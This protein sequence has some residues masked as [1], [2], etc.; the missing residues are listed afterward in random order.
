ME[1]Q[2]QERWPFASWHLSHSTRRKTHCKG[3]QRF[4]NFWQNWNSSQAFETQKPSSKINTHIKIKPA[5]RAWLG[6]RH[7]CGLVLFVSPF[8]T[9]WIGIWQ[10]SVT[11]LHSVFFLYYCVWFKPFCVLRWPSFK[12]CI[13][14]RLPQLSSV[15]FTSWFWPSVLTLKFN[16]SLPTWSGEAQRVTTFLVDCFATSTLFLMFT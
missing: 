16:L 11:F 14:H 9:N 2:T 15:V 7:T 13:W 3:F 12:S 10:F 5:V 8:M 4:T 1:Q 6:V